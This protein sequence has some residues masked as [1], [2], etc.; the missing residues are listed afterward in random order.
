MLTTK[1]QARIL[2]VFFLLAL[3]V[4]GWGGCSPA[5]VRALRKG[6][7]L[8]KE[9]K[10]PEAVEKFEEATRAYPNSAKAWN[11][12]GLGYQY[13]GDVKKSVQ[14]Y[15]QALTLDRNLTAASYNL[16][17]LYL[18]QHQ[19][20]AAVTEFTTF[21]Q[22]EPK[23]AQGWFKL[24]MAQTSQAASF[25]GAE[26]NRWFDAAKKSL[27]TAQKL[28]PSAETLNALGLLQMQRGRPQE[29]VSFF[30]SALQ[31]QADYAP[32]VLNLAVVYQQ[33]LNDHRQ[34]LIHYQQFLKI[35]GNAPEKA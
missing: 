1:K 10:Y 15:R 34:A 21:V 17:S 19:V 23:N 12:L 11:D 33:H 5:G 32:A 24:G 7:K 16:G 27:E 28:Q 8:L 29:A 20:N 13:A 2:V 3:S 31:Q 9:G 26:R 18:E 6:E 22:L 25:V 35:A 30:T 4:G 14:A